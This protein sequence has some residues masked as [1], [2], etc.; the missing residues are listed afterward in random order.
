GGV[1]LVPGMQQLQGRLASRQD[2]VGGGTGVARSDDLLET[3]P[4]VAQPSDES[5]PVLLGDLGAFVHEDQV[6]LTGQDLVVS[7]QPSHDD[8]GAVVVAVSR[9]VLCA[10]SV[11]GARAR[12][13]S[14]LGDLLPPGDEGGRS[15]GSGRLADHQCPDP[16]GLQTRQVDLGEAGTALAGTGGTAE[17]GFRSTVGEELVGGSPELGAVGQSHVR[18]SGSSPTIS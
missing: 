12:L 17:D 15:Q 14:L 16:G 8:H 11:V 2:P 4:V 18:S 7:V 9:S 6:V 10:P 13:Q 1:V 3:D 5:V